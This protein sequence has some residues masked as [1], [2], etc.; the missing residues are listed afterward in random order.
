MRRWK[1][2]QGLGATYKNLLEVFVK[3]GHSECA[4]TLCDVLRARGTYKVKAVEALL[5][6]ILNA[7]T[8][9]C[10]VT[11]FKPQTTRSPSQSSTAC[12]EVTLWWALHSYTQVH[13][14]IHGCLCMYALLL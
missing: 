2:N 13:I 6:L 9:T 10:C 12:E 8:W 5:F 7:T 14:G 1:S 4:E 3:A 11:D